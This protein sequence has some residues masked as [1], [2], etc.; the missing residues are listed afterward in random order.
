[1]RLNFFREVAN[2]HE[3]GGVLLG[4]HADDLAETTLKKILEGVP[5][6]NLASMKDSGE[7]EGLVLLRPFLKLRKKEL[8]AYWGI[9]AISQTRPT[10]PPN[11]SGEGCETSFFPC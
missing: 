6:R 8:L 4:H 2:R 3:A 1:M 10:F 11:F 5:F 9:G 7:W